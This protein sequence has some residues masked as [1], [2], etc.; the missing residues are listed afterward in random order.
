QT[1]GHDRVGIDAQKD[2]PDVDEAALA[3]MIQ[4]QLSGG[5]L[6]PD[7]FDVTIRNVS[8]H[9]HYK[10]PDGKSFAVHDYVCEAIRRALDRFRGRSNID[11]IDIVYENC[12]IERIAPN[13][14]VIADK[15]TV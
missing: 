14:L 11:G 6:E 2:R 5:L 12:D 8:L 4:S 10:F 1:A 7:S 9:D 15:H 13:Q 3:A